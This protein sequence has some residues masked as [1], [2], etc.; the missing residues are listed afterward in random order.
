MIKLDNKKILITGSNG[1]ISSNLISY[2]NNKKLITFHTSHNEIN[3]PIY[4]DLN[5]RA[6]LQNSDF[7]YFNILIHCAYKR[8]QNFEKE[9]NINFLGSKLIFDL[10]KQFNAKIIYISSMSASKNSKSNYGKI[11]YLIEKLS[12]NYNAIILRPGLVIDKN[13]NKGIYGGLQKLI[14]TYPF[15]IFPTGLNKKQFLCNIEEFCDKIYSILLYENNKN[16][17]YNFNSSELLT[18]KQ[19]CKKII[20]E[21]NKKIIF[22]NINYKIIYFFLKFLELIKINFRFKADSLLSLVD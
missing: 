9:K 5:N 8:C 14:I 12:I 6:E 18:L 11:K 15:L 2:L 22:I 17:I 4:F 20:N 16:E 3:S 10:A 7:P 1:L 21:N 19:I 13:S